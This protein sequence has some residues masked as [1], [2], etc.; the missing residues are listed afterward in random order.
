MG[1]TLTVT[2][3]S[4]PF[5]PPLRA[6]ESDGFPSTRPAIRRPNSCRITKSETRRNRRVQ[7]TYSFFKDEHPYLVWLPSDGSEPRPSGELPATRRQPASASRF[8]TVQAFSS[9][10]PPDDRTSDAPSPIPRGCPHGFGLACHHGRSRVRPRRYPRQG[11]L[12][13]HRF[14]RKGKR[15]FHG[16][17]T[18]AR[19]SHHPSWPPLAR[20]LGA[21]PK[22]GIPSRMMPDNF[23]STTQPTDTSAS[24]SLPFASDWDDPSEEEIGGS[25]M[26]RTAH[27]Q[28]PHPTTP[29]P[30]SL[31]TMAS[32]RKVRRRQRTRT[33]GQHAEAL[34]KETSWCSPGAFHQQ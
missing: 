21:E 24:S 7:S 10:T 3:S 28:F 16:F 31:R 34:A 33:L 19:T 27:W 1:K 17:A 22:K 20:P 30:S 14:P 5:C 11:R 26:L 2:P 32:V 8:D 23:C 6:N 29:A 4:P 12:P 9:R 25:R 18:A 13:L 15:S